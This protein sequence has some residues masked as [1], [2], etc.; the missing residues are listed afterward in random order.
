MGDVVEG[1]EDQA[2]LAGA[3]L[4]GGETTDHFVDGVLQVRL[5]GG[6]REGER[7]TATAAAGWV[8]DRLAGGVVVVAEGFAPE[9]GRGASVA[10]FED[11]GAE[12]A[13]VLDDFDGLV[14]ECPSPGYFLAQ[15][16]VRKRLRS[17]LRYVVGIPRS[18][19]KPFCGLNAKARRVAGLQ[20]L[21]YKLIVTG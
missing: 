4:V 12:G 3:D 17:G 11:V 20:S 5:A 2:G 9:G 1:V 18:G 21:L 6:E 19:P 14:H 10:S 7:L 16:L 15:S 13:D 8:L